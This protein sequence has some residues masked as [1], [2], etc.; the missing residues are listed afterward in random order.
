MTRL[1]DV[2]FQIHRIIG[3]AFDRFHLRILKIGLKILFSIG[4]PHPLAA[5]AGRCL[6]HHRKAD[7]FCKLK[8][9]LSRVHRLLAARHHRDS[10]FHHRLAGLGLIAHPVDQGRR[11]TDKC[12]AAFFAQLSE[13]G[14]FRKETKSRMN[15]LCLHGNGCSQ[16]SLHIQIALSR[17]RRTDADSLVSQQSMQTVPI[18]L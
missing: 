15:R 2:L 8:R 9:L 13:T 4:D 6:N 3:K 16:N 12:N 11:R 14:I 7:I 17:W 1:F 18:R 5:S 10:C